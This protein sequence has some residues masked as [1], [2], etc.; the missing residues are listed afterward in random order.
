[1]EC[2]P[3]IQPLVSQKSV[4]EKQA[5]LKINLW[6]LKKNYKTSKNNLNIFDKTKM[7]FNNHLPHENNNSSLHKKHNKL[8]LGV[9][10]Q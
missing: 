9:V 3:K 5:Y 10:K 7:N 1:M 4:Q 2:F 8:V 6:I